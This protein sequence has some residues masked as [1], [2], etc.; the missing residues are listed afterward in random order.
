MNTGRTGSSSLFSKCVPTAELFEPVHRAAYPGELIRAGEKCVPVL[1][2]STPSPV[3]SSCRLLA[4]IEACP[5]YQSNR[6]TSQMLLPL[7]PD[8]LA[9]SQCGEE[10]LRMATQCG[11]ENG[12]GSKRGG[13]P[14][15]E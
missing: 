10:K 14:S 9:A 13:L 2:S 12:E 1:E 11:E 15:R 5:Y 6:V 8:T 7:L 3:M 4:A